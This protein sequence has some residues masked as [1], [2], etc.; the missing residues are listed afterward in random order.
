MIHKIHTGEE[1]AREFKY[2]NTSFNEVRFPGYRGDCLQCHLPGTYEIPLADGRLSVTTKKDFFTPTPPETAA[3]LSCHDSKAAAAHAYANISPFG[4]SC[5]VCHGTGAD[6]TIA[7][8]H[9]RT[10]M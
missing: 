3:C 10:D 8:V 5:S 9:A 2:G 4:E 7:K 1:L 6:F